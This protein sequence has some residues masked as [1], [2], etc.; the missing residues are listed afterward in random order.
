MLAGTAIYSDLTNSDSSEVSADS[1]KQI[2]TLSSNLNF[3]GQRLS[4]NSNTISEVVQASPA[5]VSEPASKTESP[6]VTKSANGSTIYKVCSGDTLSSIAQRFGISVQKIKELN[7]LTSDMLHIGESLVING[8]PVTV[9]VSRSGSSS[10]GKTSQ[11]SAGTTSQ[12]P[13]GSATGQKVVQKAAQYLG[14]PYKYGGSS[15]SGFDCS[16]FTQYIYGQFQISLART[17]AGQ[18]GYGIS[19]NKADLLPGDLVFFHYMGGSG[20]NH[21]GIYSGNGSFIHSSS[22]SA[23]SVTYSSLSSQY[24]AANYVGAKRVIR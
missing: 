23:G 12:S 10:A 21:V 4:L 2:S 1:G 8:K 14:T 11:S 13:A 24:Y 9:A 3:L 18:Y 22:G 5:P 16:G 6:A 19:V 20:I 7:G 15:P 17:A